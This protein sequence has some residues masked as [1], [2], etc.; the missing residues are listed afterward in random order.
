MNY[1]LLT[2]GAGYIGSITTEL[3]INRGYKVIIIDN[4]QEGSPLSVS[5]KAIFFNGNFGDSDLLKKIFLEYK[6][7]FV[8]HFAASANVPD[9]V[10]NPSEYY[11]N[12][13]I[14]TL[15]L[16]NT[17]K[18]Y[19]IN[20]IIVSST[21]A[22][23]GNPID[24]PINEMHPKNPINPYGHS[25]LMMEQVLKDY[26]N[27]YGLTYIVFRYFCAAGASDFNGE[28]RKSETHLIPVILDSILDKREGVVI[29]G[30]EFNTI[31]GTGVRDYIH[32]IDIAEAHILAM[33]NFD[34]VYNQDFNLGTNNGYSVLQIINKTSDV[35][36]KNINFSYTS[37][38]PGDPDILVASNKKARALLGWEPK[39]NIDDIIRSS[40]KWR[41][42]PKY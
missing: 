11:F 4:L 39:Y 34:N 33:E 37:M 15:S 38:R 42:N 35:L 17:M 31:D 40:F 30:K 18:E 8:F 7:D 36:N 19:S 25:K 1:I 22:V 14:N 41:I 29:Y 13:L 10:L 6:I 27:A 5:N 24:L 21:A 3:L 28:S 2:G 20:K 26:S 16:L 32:V 23:F 9:S 12:N